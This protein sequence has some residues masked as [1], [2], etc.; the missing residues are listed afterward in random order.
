LRQKTKAAKKERSASFLNT[1]EVPE[2]EDV[3]TK[4][5]TGNPRLMVRERREK[6]RVDR[7]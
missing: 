5:G 7:Y 4:L 6:G 1:G 2:K 3:G